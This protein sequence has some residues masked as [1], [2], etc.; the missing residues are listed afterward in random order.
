M[1]RAFKVSTAA[2]YS[3]TSL[4]DR[5]PLHD[6]GQLEL[7]I[8]YRYGH[9]LQVFGKSFRRTCKI[10]E[11]RLQHPGR[12]KLPASSLNGFG[13]RTLTSERLVARNRH[14]PNGRH[15]SSA[16]WPTTGWPY[17]T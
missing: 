7:D 11:E 8:L 9:T 13:F 10:S 2:Q 4:A 15:H 16:A 17:D 1:V 3:K 5:R 12:P 6:E 14:V